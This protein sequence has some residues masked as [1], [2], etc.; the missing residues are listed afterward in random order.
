MEIVERLWMRNFDINKPS[1]DGLFPIH[2]AA[3]SNNSE[4]IKFLAEKGCD[5]NSNVNGIT[6]VSIALQNSPDVL[7]YLLSQ[8]VDINFIIDED[9]TP[10][11]DATIRK[12]PEIVKA[13]LKHFEIDKDDINQSDSLGWTPLLFAASNG[14]FEICKMLIQKGAD[15]N[16]HSSHGFSPLMAARNRGFPEIYSLLEKNGAKKLFPN[17]SE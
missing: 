10:L 14:S 8:N 4:V 12:K 5:I 15:V 16:C 13:I 17:S 7:D 1:D 11:I 2:Y 9:K 3:K 6:P